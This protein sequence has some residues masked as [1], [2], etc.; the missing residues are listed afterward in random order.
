MRAG[1]FFHAVGGAGGTTSVAVQKF[2]FIL[3]ASPS[4]GISEPKP[5]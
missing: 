1:L 3:T 4:K 2:P 5:H